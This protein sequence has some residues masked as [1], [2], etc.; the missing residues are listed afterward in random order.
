MGLTP[1]VI[2]MAWRETRATWR[3]FLYF[4]VCIAL[5]I[6]ALVGVGVFASNVER[7]V[8][9]EARAL[10]G[11]DL[12]IR[13]NHSISANGAS[14][15]QSLGNR[16]IK[17][18]H[19]SELIAMASRTE[20][21]SERSPDLPPHGTQIIELKAVEA[22]Y[23]F[24]GAVR[25]DPDRSLADLLTPPEKT[26]LAIAASF[27]AQGRGKGE[28]ESCYGAVVQ[29]SLLIRMGLSIHDRLQI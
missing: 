11:G 12:E 14:I 17:S 25:T 5:G 7:T 23:P 15:L 6:G 24:Y 8:T 2:I 13:L 22:G 4:F 9:R 20:S 27:A 16:G 29:E 18:T 28:G 26:C 10:M 19:A 3:H 1:F 21:A